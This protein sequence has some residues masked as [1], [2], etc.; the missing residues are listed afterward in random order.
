MSSVTIS[1]VNKCSVNRWRALYEKYCKKCI[2]YSVEVKFSSKVSVCNL[3]FVQE[4][5]EILTKI[6]KPSGNP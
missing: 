4:K 2:V 6:L 1:R 5:L 3:Q